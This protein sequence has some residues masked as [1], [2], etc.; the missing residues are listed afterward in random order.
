MIFS[1]AWKNIWRNKLRSLVILIAIALGIMSG[2]FSVGVMKGVVLQRIDAALNN[3]TSS[4]QIH[5]ANFAE[6]NEIGMLID[7][8]SQIIAYLKN[9]QEVKSVSQRI[10]TEVM[11]TSSRAVGGGYLVGINPEE[12]IKTTKICTMLLDSGGG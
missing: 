4:V 3:E 2:V 8:T 11:F 10:K 7:S 1:I 6:N 12:E 9:N 5:N